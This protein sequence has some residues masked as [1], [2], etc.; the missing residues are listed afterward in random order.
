MDYVAIE[1]S[2][3]KTFAI[4]NTC[5]A[6][7]LGLVPT[8][9]YAYGNPEAARLA[10]SILGRRIGCSADE[11]AR[12]ILDKS[13]KKI[14]DLVEPMIKEYGL[15][16]DQLVLVG[17]GGGAG[18]LIPYMAKKLEMQYKIPDYAEIISCIGV[19]A[20]LIYEERE[21]T[22]D[23][24]TAEDI[25]SL[26][27]EV[28]ERRYWPRSSSGIPK[29]RIYICHRTLAIKSHSFRKYQSRYRLFED[30]RIKPGRSQ[31]LGL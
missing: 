3:G 20:A 29:S 31:D 18:V 16:K 22:I 2:G 14:Q 1:A 23:R 12:I 24:P 8:S 6:N 28:R 26:M 27:E 9:D 19:A 30:Q 15:K 21:K 13:S 5:A 17:G 7:S 11:T 25:S 4:T 10:M